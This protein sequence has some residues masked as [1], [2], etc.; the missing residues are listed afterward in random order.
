ML[1]RVFKEDSMATQEF[2]LGPASLVTEDCLSMAVVQGRIIGF[3]HRQTG[4]FTTTIGLESIYPHLSVGA[5]RGIADK[6]LHCG[7]S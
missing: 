2:C 1:H 4:L 6:F 3:I 5:R 7:E